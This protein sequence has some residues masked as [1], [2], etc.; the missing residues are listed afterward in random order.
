MIS[1][2]SPVG[3]KPLGREVGDV[4]GDNIVVQERIQET[5]EQ[6]LVHL[7]A[8]KLLES[9]VGVRV[10]IAFLNPV[11]HGVETWSL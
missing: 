9:E 6:F 10:D 2:G 11:G 7:G 4:G 3:T 8:E 1:L 5:D